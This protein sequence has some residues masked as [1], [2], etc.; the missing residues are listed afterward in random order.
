MPEFKIVT[1]RQ[2]GRE[3]GYPTLNFEVPDPSKLP[4]F[5]IY[6]GYVDSYQAAIH[7]GPRTSF[8]ETEA[9]LEAH[10]LNFHDTWKNPTA[11]V[12]LKI[13]LRDIQN[14][15]NLED[16]KEQIAKDVAATKKL[17]KV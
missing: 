2:I 5:G 4:A 7:W 3:L 15:T 9:V 17:L 12:E 13:K 1:G 14:F 8:Q 6:A 10:L 11:K 16:L